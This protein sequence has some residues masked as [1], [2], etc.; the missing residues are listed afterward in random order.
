RLLEPR[1]RRSA[2][3]PTRGSFALPPA[4]S[5][6]APRR[7][8]RERYRRVVQAERIASGPAARPAYLPIER[9]GLIGDCGT[10]ALVSDDGSIDWLCLPRFDSDP[11]FGRILGPDAG[12]FVVRPRES[13]TAERHYLLDTAVL[14]TTYTTPSGRATVYD[15]FAAK[16]FT[17]KRRHLWPFRY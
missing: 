14:A 12:H 4:R 13:F 10:A 7:S 11:I 2:R 16:P 15:F 9:Y 3:R 1:R 17:E 8:R 5:T 6:S